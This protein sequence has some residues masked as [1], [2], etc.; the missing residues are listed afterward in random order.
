[1]RH[2][3]FNNYVKMFCNKTKTWSCIRQLDIDYMSCSICSFKQNIYLISNY[4]SCYVY[5]FKTNKLNR[6]ADMEERFDS[7]CTVFEGKIVVSGG[8]SLS[9][10]YQEL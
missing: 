10:E 3:E 7:A 2:D 5:N 4:G 9:H 1:M 6:K 8:I